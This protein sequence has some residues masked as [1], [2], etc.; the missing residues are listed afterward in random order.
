M[1]RRKS[2]R[3]Q[4][5]N[6]G[7]RFRSRRIG[8]WSLRLPWCL[9]LSAWGICSSAPACRYNIREIG[10]VGVQQPEFRFPVFV[11]GD[12]QKE[13]LPGFQQSG[14][15][16]LG[17]SN[18]SWEVIDE[19]QQASSPDLRRR[20]QLGPRLPGGIVLA[21]GREDGWP[22]FLHVADAELQE[23]LSALVASS[24]R[25]QITD[26]VINSYGAVLLLRG[27]EEA[28]NAAAQSLAREA[29]KVVEST[30]ADLPKRIARGPQLVEFDPSLPAE[31]ITAWSLGVNGKDLTQP[32]VAVVYGRGRLAGPALHGESLTAVKLRDQL[33]LIGADCECALD[34]S[35]MTAGSIPLAISSADE[36]LIS[37]AL[38]FDPAAA[39]LK[40]EVHQILL[41][42]SQAA[43]DPAAS[44]GGGYRETPL[45]GGRYHVPHASEIPFVFD[46]LDK[47][48]SIGGEPTASAQVL[49][50]RMS[51][52]WANF[53][54]NG[55]P[56]GGKTITW[57]KYNSATRPTM[58]WDESPAG[59]RIEND[60]R[61]EQRKRM[62][63]YGSQQYA[64]R[65]SGAG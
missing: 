17:P 58:M 63:A 30:L 52:A 41:T 47:A 39:S 33:A 59:P 54:R 35:W 24:A 49:A 7:G 40:A 37:T 16:W 21:A 31:Q 27:K 60:P 38:G 43:R 42:Q 20:A 51:A 44:R 28:S 12:E 32:V 50:D 18:I 3:P 11:H 13:W 56:N 29:I 57:P 34:H 45:E 1:R 61:A 53:A 19:V 2:T 10:F 64:A 9:V 36:T 14:T 15:R 22:V 5:P 65:E 26:A 23:K 62:L 6:F 4:R 48:T 55:D 8:A 25:R 46:T